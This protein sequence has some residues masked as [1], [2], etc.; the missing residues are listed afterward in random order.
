MPSKDQLQTFSSWHLYAAFTHGLFS[1]LV[2]HMC[3]IT[4]IQDFL[5]LHG[6]TSHDTSSSYVYTCQ[7]GISSVDHAMVCMPFWGFLLLARH[8]E[9]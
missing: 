5:K 1:T 8:N 3:T 9:I 6:I 7:G 2:F 4:D